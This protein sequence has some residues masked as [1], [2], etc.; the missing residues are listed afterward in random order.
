MT[1]ITD[2]Q[3]ALNVIRTIER[4]AAAETRLDALALIAGTA[5]DIAR[6]LN[7]HNQPLKKRAGAKSSAGSKA[8]KSA[9]KPLPIPQPPKPAAPSP[10]S[11]ALPSKN[12]AKPFTEPELT[13]TNIEVKS[14]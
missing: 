3:K 9:P 5:A 2:I 10:S 6:D 4:E 13:N 7:G 14:N 12:K 11:Q 1:A 8:N